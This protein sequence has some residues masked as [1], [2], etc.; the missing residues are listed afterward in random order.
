MFFNFSTELIFLQKY[1]LIP[2]QKPQH[3]P[4]KPQP[5]KYGR[6]AQEPMDQD[7]NP[8]IDDTRKKRIQNIVG[9]I[10]FYTHATD[11][12][13]LM[14]LTTIARKQAKAKINTDILVDHLLDYCATHPNAAILYQA[15]NMV[16][17]IHSDASYLS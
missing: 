6:A 14:A 11:L 9:S 15:S 16:L 1:N 10:L 4:Y 3:C 7:K 17:N 2:P 5:R 13:V 12:I 8:N